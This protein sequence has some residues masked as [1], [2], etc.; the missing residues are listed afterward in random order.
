MYTK[1]HSQHLDKE[2]ARG[3]LI[4]DQSHW[5]PSHQCRQLCCLAR[6]HCC[7]VWEYGKSGTSF[8]SIANSF[9]S[10]GGLG[11][12]RE[13]GP[14]S[15]A[16][17]RALLL[18]LVARARLPRSGSLLPRS[19]ALLPRS[20]ACAQFPRS[21]ALLPRPAALPPRSGEWPLR[22]GAV[23]PRS[24][25]VGSIATSLGSVAYS[26]KRMATSVGSIA[27]SPRSVAAGSLRRHGL[28]KRPHHAVWEH[29]YFAREQ[30]TVREHRMNTQY[31]INAS[32]RGRQTTVRE[33][34]WD[35]KQKVSRDS[36]SFCW[37][38]QI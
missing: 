33:Q 13:H 37:A 31:T 4:S 38:Q 27:T 18:R 14:C 36:L 17:S 2:N 29:C 35:A 28:H 25:A 11:V 5:G 15:M 26:L 19:G 21:G 32:A 10:T 12:V 30:A 6:A 9:G 23:L 24:S 1:T 34:P 7:I 8:G 20:S 3:N 16:R 22:A